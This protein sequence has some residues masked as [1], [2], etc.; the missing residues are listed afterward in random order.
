M[1]ILITGGN[2]DIARVINK[3]LSSIDYTITNVSRSELDV[4]NELE[5]EKY[6]KLYQF[7]ILVHTAILGGRR[8]KEENEDI[9]HKNLLM[10]EN[11]LKF[12][13]KFKMIINF[14]SAAIYVRNTDILNRREQDIYTI[15]TDYYG[16]S[17]YLIY[18]RSLQY[19]NVY[20]LRIFNIFHSSEEPER[21]IKSCFI[22]KKN[23]TSVTIFNDKYFDFVY[24]DD[25]VKIVKYYFDNIN[26]QEN[27]EKTINICYEEKYK[28]SDIAKIIMG[29]HNDE[30]IDI[31]STLSDKN[32]SGDNAKL[33]KY[34]LEFLGLENSIKICEGCYFYTMECE[35]CGII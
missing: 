33:K 11:M 22:A 12:S 1:R 2:G 30:K 6:L 23:N 10:F 4:L 16:L 27:L 18:Q 21:F 20:N 8:T 31:L 3:N 25:F 34:N 28:L 35:K 32:Y 14:D 7:D 24:E 13:D 19:N 5:I 26:S 17:K 9:T 15:P 29:P